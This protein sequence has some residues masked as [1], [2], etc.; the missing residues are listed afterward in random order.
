MSKAVTKKDCEA[1]YRKVVLEEDPRRPFKLDSLD[2]SAIM[3]IYQDAIKKQGATKKKQ[4]T[5]ST[6]G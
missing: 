6:R 5:H 2:R 3:V 1:Y 4:S